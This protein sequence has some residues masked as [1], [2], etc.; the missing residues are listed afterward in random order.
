MPESGPR[1]GGSDGTAVEHQRQLFAVIN[2]VAGSGDA[3]EVR[4]TL[5]ERF[6]A[7]ALTIYE[8]TGKEN[9]AAVVRQAVVEGAELVVA[10]GGDGTVS[11]VAAGLVQSGV[12][13]GIIPLGTGNALAQELRL[14]LVALDACKLLESSNAYRNID[15]MEVGDDYAVL[16]MGV[17]LESIAVETTERSL[18]R[19]LGVWAYVWTGLKQ[20]FGW[21]PCAFTLAVDGET[22]QFRASE[23]FVA[24]AARVGVFELA[25]GEHIRPD[26][27]LIDVLV[28]N[29]RSIVDYLRAAWAIVLRQQRRVPYIR[30]Y[31]VSER[32][33]V[34]SEEPLPVHRDGEVFGTTPFEVKVLPGSLRVVVKAD[35]RAAD[36][37][38]EASANKKNSKGTVE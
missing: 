14:P 24:N 29:A 2:P 20:A 17:G 25:W 3:A 30:F 38:H 26:D 11:A 33:T 12:P 34:A 23:I 22:K 21:Q 4:L 27:G 32:L 28:I 18:K 6:P 15:V 13:L 1:R 9:I 16:K 31:E 36:A 37:D 10:A 19:L 7:E 8:T 35:P 5:E